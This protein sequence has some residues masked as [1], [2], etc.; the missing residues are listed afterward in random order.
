MGGSNYIEF[1]VK[2]ISQSLNLIA[3]ATEVCLP[4]LDYNFEFSNGM[5]IIL[6]AIQNLKNWL[7]FER[8]FNSFS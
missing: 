8:V 6:F 3:Y 4:I 5:N 7:V 2:K 1:L